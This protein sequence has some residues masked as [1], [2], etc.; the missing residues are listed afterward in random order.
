MSS[1]PGS[2]VRITSNEKYYPRQSVLLKINC[3]FVFSFFWQK[4][5][6]EEEK[7]PKEMEKAEQNTE[8]PPAKGEVNTCSA[9]ILSLF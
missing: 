2:W 6:A 1:N 9:S 7:Q 8:V 5:K 3:F 4:E